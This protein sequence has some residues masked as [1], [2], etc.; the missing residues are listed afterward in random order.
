MRV[1]LSEA[2]RLHLARMY[3]AMVWSFKGSD[4]TIRNLDDLSEADRQA[5][6]NGR[7]KGHFYYKQQ[8]GHTVRTVSDNGE[9]T[10]TTTYRLSDRHF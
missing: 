8:I 7:I 1:R 4:G 10:E 2:S 5:V 9:I 3:D 6:F